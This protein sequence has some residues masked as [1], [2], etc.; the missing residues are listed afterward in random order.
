MKNYWCRVVIAV[1]L[2]DSRAHG[3][4]I[5]PARMQYI[6]T[7]SANGWTGACTSTC[8]YGGPFSVYFRQRLFLAKSDYEFW[9]SFGSRKASK[10]SDRD[11]EATFFSRKKAGEQN[12]RMFSI[13]TQV[14]D[15]SNY[16]CK[17]LVDYVRFQDQLCAFNFF[18]WLS[19][20]FLPYDICC[21]QRLVQA[22]EGAALCIPGPHMAPSPK[23]CGICKCHRSSYRRQCVFCKRAV[24]PGCWPEQC[25]S[26]QF[27]QREGVC[28]ECV[29][30]QPIVK[31]L[32]K[33][34]PEWMRIVSLSGF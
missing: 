2:W 8:A 6:A 29:D 25:L 22:F 21:A 34:H 9:N 31:R 19:A 15:W 33:S 1:S 4:Y 11:D 32:E 17:G 3:D 10:S 5:A 12:K 20:T 16:D 30:L 26:K 23:F 24:A 14:Q 27:S 28:R 7:N 18:H 13:L